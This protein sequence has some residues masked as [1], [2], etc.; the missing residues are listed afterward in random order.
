MKIQYHDLD[1]GIRLIELNGK[2][3]IYGVNEIDQTFIRYCTGDK[4]RVIV[5]LSK[6]SY[7]SSIGMPMLINTAKAIF[8]NGGKM[9]LLAPPKN[10]KE[11]LTMAGIHLIIPISDDF[12]SA[13]TSLMP[14]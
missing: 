13:K 2:L 1:N 6:I 7:L 5:D 10:V 11:I 14:S 8:R 3:D 9:V 4:L 12:P